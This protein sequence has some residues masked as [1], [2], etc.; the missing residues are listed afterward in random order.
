MHPDSSKAILYAP[1][2]LASIGAGILFPMP[3][4]A[5]QAR[6]RGEDIGIAT[7]IQVF[8]R[9]L[10][11]AFG[12]GLGGVIFQNEWTRIV[13]R[14][15]RENKIPT[16]LAIPGSHAEI[17]Y[18]II[19]NFPEVIQAA[20]RWVFSDSLKTIWWVLMGLSIGGF[21][22]SLTARNDKVA[23]GLSGSQNFDDKKAIDS[24]LED[25]RIQNK[26]SQ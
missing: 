24:G 10:G 25:G 23:G 16:S 17:A 15:V 6:Q 4:F 13:S 9:S 20:Y 11:T 1:R 26:G 19:E 14:N 18:E 5:V 3:L 22:V 2:C 21:L 12:V 7:S 8:A